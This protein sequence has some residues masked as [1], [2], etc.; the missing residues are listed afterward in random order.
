MFPIRPVRSPSRLRTL[1]AS[2]AC[3][4]AIGLVATPAL[5]ATQLPMPRPVAEAVPELTEAQK[6]RIETAA[7]VRETLKAAKAGRRGE[8]LSLAETHGDPA[9]KAAADWVSLRA[10]EPRFE[11]IAAFREAH[12]QWPDAR[13]RSLAERD[14]HRRGAA[15]ALV[16]EAFD[17]EPPRTEA[18]RRAYAR[19]LISVD[20]LDEARAQIAR[21]YR[22]ARM[23]ASD[24]TAF[25]KV[26]GAALTGAEHAERA[27]YQLYFDRVRAA[28][29]AI[30]RSDDAL[31]KRR[32]AICGAV[33]RKQALPALEEADRA[34][35]HIAYCL[36]E[37]ATPLTA[38]H[39]LER[40]AGVGDA[41]GPRSRWTQRRGIARRML[42]AGQT[43][44]AYEVAA[45]HGITAP[46]Q[47]SEAEAMAGWIAL[48]GLGDPDLAEPHFRRVADL[49]SRPISQ[50]R[51]AYWLGRTHDARDET[52]L[53]EERYRE[54]ASYPTTYYGQLAHDRLGLKTLTL[55]ALPVSDAGDRH[56][57]EQRLS[58]RA[59][60]LLAGA[61]EHDLATAL[62]AGLANQAEDPATAKLAARLVT[63][64][65]SPKAQVGIGKRASYRGMALEPYA[66][67]TLD[68]ISAEAETHGVGGAVLHAVARQESL[69]DAGAGSHVGAKGLMQLMPAT[70]REVSGRLG[71]RYSRAR[72]T[73]DPTYNVQ[74]GSAYIAG[75]DRRFSGAMPMMFA[76]Y[77]AGPGRVNQW[78]KRYGDP[79][80]SVEIAIDWVERIPFEETRNYVMR[81]ME[82]VSVYR[83]RLEGGTAELAIAEDLLG[84]KRDLA[85]IA[86]QHW[87]KMRSP[88]L[89][90]VSGPAQAFSGVP[91]L[92]RER[93][94]ALGGPA[95]DLVETV[96]N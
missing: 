83:A 7:L 89:Q 91:P 22:E 72:L 71:L 53:A 15:P 74:L 20:R 48:R 64:F 80:E 18:G 3:S 9:L 2:L 92:P 73:Q 44:L 16:L 86:G 52:V 33:I 19:A 68:V 84:R 51:A 79:R 39:H 59:M 41:I 28:E 46:A 81:V 14:L 10:L 62:A 78:V 36:A 30:A 45:H 55:P 29:R 38:A 67:P 43:T 23:S 50:A 82:N 65:G 96:E 42:D 75:L 76:G 63:A 56:A 25:L 54:A 11:T 58:V 66:F 77:N 88:V 34:D 94:R 93:L 5:S 24:E 85:A 37:K 90:A 49:T 1:L 40:V 6:A 31:A 69:F 70:A 57:F 35:P 17:A 13:L 8:A 12:P 4:A 61:G 27:T 26:Y 21:L 47:A 95:A 87:T 60:H 32:V